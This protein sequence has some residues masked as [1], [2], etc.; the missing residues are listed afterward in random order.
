MI[1]GLCY[2]RVMG[3][4]Q[5]AQRPQYPPDHDRRGEER[6]PGD[7]QNTC[8]RMPQRALSLLHSGQAC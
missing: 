2:S 5:V 3:I 6:N 7:N 1:S 4:L 8:H